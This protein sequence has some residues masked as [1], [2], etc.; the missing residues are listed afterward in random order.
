[1]K[2][3]YFAHPVNTYNKP[4][5]QKALEILASEFPDCEVVNPNAPEHEESYKK[6]GMEYFARM[7]RSTQ[8]MAILPFDDGS[9]GAGIAKE[10]LESL[11]QGSPVFYLSPPNLEVRKL[12]G[13][14]GLVV[15]TI[16][17]TRA[18]LK[19]KREEYV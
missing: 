10:A 18:R 14:S 9:I 8:A 6:E 13:L 12:E 16:E 3:L 4:I 5:E 1:M 11:V 19:S 7:V 2:K 15:L 17:Q